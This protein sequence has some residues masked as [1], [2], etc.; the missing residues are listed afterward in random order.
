MEH[1]HL[2]YRDIIN[3]NIKVHRQE[4]LVYNFI[5]SE[6]WNKS[7]QMRLTRVLKRIAQLID[8]CQFRAM[9]FG[10]GTGNITEKLLGLGFKVTAVDISPE[11][12]SFLIA[13]NKSD[14]EV[15]KLKVS[16]FKTSPKYFPDILVNKEL[17]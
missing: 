2:D 5:H 11:M 7:E 10:A 6:I 12:C 13:H 17:K 1:L 9:D 8:N 4:C 3:G 16:A 15:G 14:V